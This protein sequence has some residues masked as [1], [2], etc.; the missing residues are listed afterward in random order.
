M[1]TIRKIQNKSGISYKAIIK[2]PFGKQKSKNFSQ[3]KLAQEWAKRLELDIE[4][5]E[6]YL[7]Q[8]NKIQ[9]QDLIVE[10]LEQWEGKDAS[11]VQRLAF[12]SK[13]IGTKLLVDISTLHIRNG[14][15]VLSKTNA[16]KYSGSNKTK[17]TVFTSKKLSHST[18]NRYKAAL[19]SVLSYG[20]DKGYID[21]NP[22]HRIKSYKASKPRLRYLNTEEITRLL[23]SCQASEWSKLY[24]LVLMALTSGARKG[25]LLGLKW[26]DIDYTHNFAYLENTKIMRGE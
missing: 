11:M 7:L 17:K 26:C 16:C 14:L 19:S 10:Y 23:A 9:L 2:L 13:H 24:L 12:W 8:G 4:K 18:I 1:A 15:D 25:E 5:T 20:V 21:I 22:C 3:K 6:A